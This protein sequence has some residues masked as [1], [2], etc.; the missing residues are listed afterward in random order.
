[1]PNNP[2]LS[3]RTQELQSAQ[4]ELAEQVKRLTEALAEQTGRRE[5]TELPVREIC[6][7]R[8]ELEAQLGLLRV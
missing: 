7:R 8:N 1:M 6:E 3:P 2:G 4:A 5:S